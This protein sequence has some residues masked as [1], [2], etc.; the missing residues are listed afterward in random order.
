MAYHHFDLN[1]RF[2]LNHS[3]SET[4]EAFNVFLVDKTRMFENEN[5]SPFIYPVEK[6]ITPKRR[7]RGWRFWRKNET[8]TRHSR[9]GT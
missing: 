6:K 2:V 5:H 4:I 9:A 8:R 3:L 1:K 7:D